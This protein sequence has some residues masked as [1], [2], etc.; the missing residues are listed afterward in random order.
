[1]HPFQ[2]G[3]ACM[4]GVAFQMPTIGVAKSLLCGHLQSDQTIRLND[5][6]IGAAFSDSPRVKKPV[7]ISPGHNISLKSAVTI[8]QNCSTYKS[9]EPLRLAHNLA[10]ETLRKHQEN[11]YLKQQE[12]QVQHTTV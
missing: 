10:T 4:V 7:Y 12:T 9:P 6:V 8:V 1:L 11:H 2:S 5:R 3:I